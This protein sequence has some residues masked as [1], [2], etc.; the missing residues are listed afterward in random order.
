ML[1]EVLLVMKWR[2]QTR[3]HQISTGAEAFY[4]LCGSIMRDA[5]ASALA[6]SADLERTRRDGSEVGNSQ[7]Y[8][9]LLRTERRWVEVRW[10][11][12]ECTYRGALDSLGR[13]ANC[14]T[15]TTAGRASLQV[16]TL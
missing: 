7:L 9:L 4:S 16:A 12:L 14:R 1:S 2:L 8:R 15:R 3:M 13:G 5:A 10:R 6:R 11:K